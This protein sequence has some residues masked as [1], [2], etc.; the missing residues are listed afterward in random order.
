M[1]NPGD[2]NGV[3]LTERVRSALRLPVYAQHWD[4]HE[5]WALA[6]RIWEH[7]LLG[8]PD[9]QVH[10]ARYE[11]A[12]ALAEYL[13]ISERVADLAHRGE[14]RGYRPIADLRAEAAAHCIKAEADV[15]RQVDLLIAVRPLP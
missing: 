7:D 8:R 15:R 4:R 13:R 1:R 5:Y 12:A 11:T 9:E 2:E 10:R 6:Q 14:R 3:D